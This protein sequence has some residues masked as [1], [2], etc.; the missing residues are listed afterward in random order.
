MP[1]ER[2]Q[3]DFFARMA[4]PQGVREVFE[5]LPG[6]FFF[7]KDAQGRHIAANTATFDRFGIKHE[8]ELVGTTDERWFPAEVAEGFRRDDQFVIKTNKPI[9]NRLKI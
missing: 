3:V 9:L 8:S 6:V 1:S 7:V 4:D 2:L 5:H